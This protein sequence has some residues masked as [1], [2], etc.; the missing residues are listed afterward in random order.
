MS[1]DS[2]TA[3]SNFLYDDNWIDHPGREGFDFTKCVAMT[4]H[5]LGSSEITMR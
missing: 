2:V 5:Y 3:L 1:P 4:I